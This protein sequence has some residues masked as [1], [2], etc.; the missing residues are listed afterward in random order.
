MRPGTFDWPPQYS[1]DTVSQYQFLI[2]E[3]GEP[4][5]ITG[6][7]IK[8]QVRASRSEPPILDLSTADGVSIV[9][10][11]GPNGTL[12]V[13]NFRNPEVSGAFSY[14]LEVTFP[15][16]RVKTYFRGSYVIDGDI[17]R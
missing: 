1:G 7:T 14:D 13:G 9:I 5:S 17:T 15:D 12:R 16:G 10:T 4:V 2:L 6:S 11:D 3:N 8:M